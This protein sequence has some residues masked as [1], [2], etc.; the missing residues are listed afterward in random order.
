M[1]SSPGASS[2][3]PAHASN[4]HGREYDSGLHLNGAEDDYDENEEERR[5]Q[6][7]SMDNGDVELDEDSG[8]DQ[9]DDDSNMDMEEQIVVHGTPTSIFRGTAS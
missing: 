5:E 4:G 6:M 3:R 9:S 8:E 1:L 2:S 7:L